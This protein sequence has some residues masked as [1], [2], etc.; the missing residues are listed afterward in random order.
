MMS[1]FPSFTDFKAASTQEQIQIFDIL[2]E[3]TDSLIE[4]TLKRKDIDFDIAK[5]S[6][7]HDLIELVRERLLQLIKDDDRYKSELSNIIAAHPKLGVPKQI[8]GEL[9]ELS[10][11]EQKNLNDSQNNGPEIK[12]ALIKLN[13]AYENKYKGLRFVCFV[14]GRNRVEIIG[15]MNDIL[16]SSNSWNQEAERAIN[17]MCDIA[18]D[19][20]Q[21]L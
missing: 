21:K 18:L 11:L 17:A 1:K 2:F 8:Q 6:S 14:N 15:E 19:R 7:Y 12:E 20:F 9:S 13:D 10:K 4:F 5:L 16:N 3:H